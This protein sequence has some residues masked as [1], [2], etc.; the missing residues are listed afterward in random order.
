M[1]VIAPAPL[2]AISSFINA[3]IHNRETIAA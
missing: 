2:S 3:K 1:I